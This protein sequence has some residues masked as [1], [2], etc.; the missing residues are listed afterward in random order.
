MDVAGKFDGLQ[1]TVAGQ[2]L[3]VVSSQWQGDRQRFTL[4]HEL[5]HLLLADRLAEGLDEEKACNHFA[6]AFL[7]PGESVRQ[8]LG[9]KRH[10]IEVRELYL[11][12]HEFGLS[13]QACLYRLILIDLEEGSLLRRFFELPYEFRVPDI[14]YFEELEAQHSYLLDFGLTLGELGEQGM[15]TAFAY[16][17]QYGAPSRNDCFALALAKQKACPLLT[18]DKAL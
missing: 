10:S 17:Q 3:I 14:L 18:G 12:K 4:A 2:P 7:L 13:M 15:R 11:L 8:H 16:T 9:A 6:S 1:A 5:G